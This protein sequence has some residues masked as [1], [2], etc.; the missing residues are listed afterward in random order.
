MLK[1]KVGSVAVDCVVWQECFILSISSDSSDKTTPAVETR[2]KS[3]STYIFRDINRR[4][5]FCHSGASVCGSYLQR[6][7]FQAFRF[8]SAWLLST[9]GKEASPFAR[10]PRWIPS[11]SYCSCSQARYSSIPSMQRSINSSSMHPCATAEFT[12]EHICL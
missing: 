8:S 6:R 7:Y 11:S 9:R 5:P 4:W 3:V 10:Q 2:L 1:T 12:C